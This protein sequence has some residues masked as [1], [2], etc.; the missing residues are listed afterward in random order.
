MPG[1][2]DE[3]QN[4]MNQAL[5]NSKSSAAA[6]QQ[7]QDSQSGQGKNGAESDQAGDP[8]SSGPQSSTEG[9]KDGESESGTNS[10][11]GIK[12]NGK[13]TS[14]TSGESLLSKLKDALNSLLAQSSQDK[15]IPKS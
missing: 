4:A 1:D 2:P 11:S 14:G 15:K 10:P 3:L 5:Q 13:A 12:V 8:L 6:A 9:L 7:G